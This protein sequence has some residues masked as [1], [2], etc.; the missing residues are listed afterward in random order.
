VSYLFFVVF[1]DSWVFVNNLYV[2]IFHNPN[3]YWRFVLELFCEVCEVHIVVLPCSCIPNVKITCHVFPTRVR[4]SENVPFPGKFTFLKSVM[5]VNKALARDFLKFSS[6]NFG[7]VGDKPNAIIEVEDMADEAKEDE[8]SWKVKDGAYDELY[9]IS[10]PF[11]G[12]EVS[13]TRSE[14]AD[15]ICGEELFTSICEAAIQAWIQEHAEE[16]T[17]KL[18]G[19]F[20]LNPKKKVRKQ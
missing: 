19:N 11:G 17:E 12:A 10:K 6:R 13:Q 3:N 4:N 18:L 15:V 2:D 14:A 1:D 8:S 16:L 7:S 20:T 5:N 9:K